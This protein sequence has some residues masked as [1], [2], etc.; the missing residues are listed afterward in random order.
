VH[1]DQHG[2][3]TGRRMSL[4]IVAAAFAAVL[5]NPGPVAAS[6]NPPT[7]PNASYTTPLNTPLSGNLLASATDPENDTLSIIAYANFSVAFG[8]ITFTSAQGD[9]TFAPAS[10]AYGTASTW[11]NVSDGT[12]VIQATLQITIN[13]ILCATPVASTGAEDAEQSGTLSCTDASNGTL[14]YALAGGA[15]S[16]TVDV[17]SDGAWTYTPDADFNGSDSFSY[18]A[19]DGAYVSGAAVASI[20]VTPVD[21]A[22]VC[23]SPASSS[24]AQNTQQSGTLSCTDIDGPSLT[25]ALVDQAS[26]GTASVDADGSWTYQP[27]AGYKGSDSFTFKASDGSLDSGTATMDLTVT[28]VS[29]PPVVNPP[30]YH[31]PANQAPVCTSPSPSTGR[32]GEKQSGTLSCTDADSTSLTYALVDQATHGTAVV[33][34]DGS[35]TYVPS[36]V[37][38]VGADSFTFK[39]SDGSLD[40]NT[41][42]ASIS[43]LADTTAPT[44]SVP[45]VSL[46]TGRINETAP[47]RLAWSASDDGTGVATYSVEVRIGAGAWTSVYSG[48]GTTFTKSYKLNAPLMWRVRATDFAGNASAWTYTSKHKVVAYQETSKAITYRGAWSRE[49][50]VES[51]GTGYGYVG[52][53]GRSA[54]LRFTGIDVLYVA[55]KVARGGF[56]KVFVDD[57]YL[58]RYS[59]HHASTLLGQQIARATWST[60]GTHTI[61]I[62]DAQSGRRITLDAFVILR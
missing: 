26:H 41:A 34:D 53:H 47:V 43:V 7:V 54:Q 12:N 59:T 49:R 10:D 50:S 28:A 16:G 46:G 55:P 38:Y 18:T 27:A 6:G 60:S 31:A 52:L 14:T 44:V 19:T 15:S 48:S 62:V 24:G 8:T 42:T 33:N 40:S 36:S 30:V 32:Q 23:A 21:D 58:G 56:V 9:F 39:A 2:A 3:Q 1:R 20:T 4:A 17:A 11:F 61:K 29:I 57:R 13:P 45:A 25:Y 37:S 35:W 5:T 22:P 51:S